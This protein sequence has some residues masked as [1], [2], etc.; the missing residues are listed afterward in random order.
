MP[1]GPGR[2]GDYLTDRLTDHALELIKAHHDQ[3]FFISLWF[4]TVHTPI[5]GKPDLVKH[6]EEKPP[7]RIHDHPSYAAM[8]AS[9][10]QNLDRLLRELDRS[11]LAESTIVILTSDN[12][13][14]DF[15]TSKSGNRPPTRNAPFRSGKGTL[16]EGG[17][18]VPL[19]IRWPGLTQPGT[20][21][22]ELVT[23]QDFFPDVC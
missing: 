21:C 8:L 16:Y 3:P 4:H 2:P 14:V 17:I 13:G 9:L 12:G 5:E 15:E 23:S 1:V 20:I 18:R 22:D 7:G 19:M 6:F 10:D 11:G